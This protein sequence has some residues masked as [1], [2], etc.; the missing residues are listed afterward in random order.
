MKNNI[1]HKTRLLQLLACLIII[2]LFLVSCTNKV[3]LPNSEEAKASVLEKITLAANKWSNG[4][5]MGYFECAAEDIIWIDD[6][7][8]SV[9]IIG[10]E[11]LKNHLQPFNGKIPKHEFKL[12]E[13]VFQV[14][15]DI[16]IVTYQYQGIFEGEPATPWKVSSV[17]K[18]DNGDWLSVH[19]NWT[20]VK[21]KIETGK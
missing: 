12:S 10:S 4:D 13:P 6:L 7:G 2:N 11:A 15:N 20:E 3:E 14:Y 9:T 18:Y 8:P 5:S 17:Y 21:E 16:A 1:L 19:E